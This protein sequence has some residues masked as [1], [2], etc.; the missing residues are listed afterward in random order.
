[1]LWLRHEVF[2]GVLPLHSSS[3]APELTPSLARRL[4]SALRKAGRRSEAR[5]LNHRAGYGSGGSG[6]NDGRDADNCNSDE[7]SDAGVAV[8]YTSWITVSWRV[9]SWSEPTAKLF[10]EM[11]CLFH[12]SNDG[13]QSLS[14][15]TPYP[16]HYSYVD[17]VAGGDMLPLLANEG[18]SA[19]RS[20]SNTDG[21]AAASALRELPLADLAIFLLLHVPRFATSP[22]VNPAPAAAFNESWP[23]QLVSEGVGSVGDHV[24]FE[25]GSSSSSSSSSSSAASTLIAAHAASASLGAGGSPTGGGGG[26]LSPR[27]SPRQYMA[28]DTMHGSGGG[29]SGD[30]SGSPRSP[31]SARAL[32]LQTASSAEAHRLDFVR[33]HIYEVGAVRIWSAYVRL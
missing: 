5:Q 13:E 15:P 17:E 9:L 21:M 28:D 3:S 31:S 20:S 25:S 6:H 30:G 12:L 16:Y 32:A 22:R 2:H 4:V 1:M 19:G 33:Q 26:S 27:G 8:Y 14:S 29:G 7:V 10:W 18:S 24:V 11:V 23:M